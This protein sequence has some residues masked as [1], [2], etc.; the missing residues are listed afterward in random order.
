MKT[1]IFICM[2]V[3]MIK[4]IHIYTCTYLHNAMDAYDLQMYATIY[5]ALNLYKQPQYTFNIIYIYIP[6]YI[7]IIFVLKQVIF[8]N[9]SKSTHAKNK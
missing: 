8:G 4:S 3:C 6:T 9:T 1:N 2:T 7:H 5:T